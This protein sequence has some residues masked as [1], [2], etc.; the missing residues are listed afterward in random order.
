MN[1]LGLFLAKS[2]TRNVVEGGRPCRLRGALTV[3]SE[4]MRA[5]VV[6]GEE[7][8][9]TREETK[10]RARISAPMAVLVSA[11]VEP[12]LSTLLKVK[13]RGNP[14]FAWKVMG[15]LKP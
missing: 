15:V 6:F 10:A 12:R 5:S 1:V 4:G 8:R 9:V 7:I 14:L 11:L 3:E 13:V 2:L